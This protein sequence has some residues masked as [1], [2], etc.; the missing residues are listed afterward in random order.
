MDDA[1]MAAEPHVIGQGD[2]LHLI[3]LVTVGPAPRRRA[4]AEVE[5]DP[6]F[7]NHR[8]LDV[9]ARIRASRSWGRIL[10]SA[11]MGSPCRPLP[12]GRVARSLPDGGVLRPCIDA[13][14]HGEGIL[15]V[16]WTAPDTSQGS[17]KSCILCSYARRGQH[18]F[19]TCPTS[20]AL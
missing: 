13:D 9:M 12:D 14:G 20:F 19:T 15:F 4:A 17:M 18:V 10:R 7:P 3:A 11:S 1:R 16:F 8:A 5:D 2:E 6:W